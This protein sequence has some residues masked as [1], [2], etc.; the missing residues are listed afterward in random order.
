[1]QEALYPTAGVI[2]RRAPAVE[3]DGP[4]FELKLNVTDSECILVADSS[5]SDSAIVILR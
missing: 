4:V 3:S 5:Q 2:S 1:M